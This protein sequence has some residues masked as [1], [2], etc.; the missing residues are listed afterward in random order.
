MGID[1]MLR[2]IIVI[3]SLLATFMCVESGGAIL[4]WLYSTKA[5]RIIYNR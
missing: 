4:D 3:L 5:Y 2:L 1:K